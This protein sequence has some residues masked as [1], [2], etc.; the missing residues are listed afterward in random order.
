[1]A[2]PDSWLRRLRCNQWVGELPP[3]RLGRAYVFLMKSHKASTFLNRPYRNRSPLLSYLSEYHDP[4]EDAKTSGVVEMAPWPTGFDQDGVVQWD[5]EKCEARGGSWKKVRRRMEQKR[6]EPE[7]VRHSLPTCARHADSSSSSSSTASSS[8]LRDTGRTSRTGSRRSTLGPGR[9]ACATSSSRT[10]RMSLSSV[11]S[12]LELVRCFLLQ[13]ERHRDPD[14]DPLR[15]LPGAIPPIAEQQSMWWT[16]WLTGKMPSLPKTPSNYYLL[17]PPT[18]R[19]KYG[20]DHTTYMHT[21]AADFGGSPAL[22]DLWRTHGAF[23]TLVYAFSAAFTSHY[24]LIGPF[25]SDKAPEVVKTEIWETVTRRGL[26]GN[27]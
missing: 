10:C 24:R 26:L 3:E 13:I 9:P 25:K 12:D 6:I 1:M 22:S 2:N 14:S 17:S 20:V 23:V 15:R 16:A 21:L 5:W 7:Y 19:I 11:S 27:L 8:S 4:E 18:A